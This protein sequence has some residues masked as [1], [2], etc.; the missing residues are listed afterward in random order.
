M[1]SFDRWRQ[2]DQARIALTLLV[3]HTLLTLSTLR[4]E[5]ERGR[6]RSGGMKERERREKCVW[7]EGGRS[8]PRGKKKMGERGEEMGLEPS[9]SQPIALKGL[10][11]FKAG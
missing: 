11:E 8:R 9:P 6:G 3:D 2:R 1:K 4:E 5:E 7:G 10:Q